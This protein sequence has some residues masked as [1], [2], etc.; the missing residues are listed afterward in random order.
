MLAGFDIST[1][2][3]SQP[4]YLWL[5]VVPAVLLVLGGWRV[6]R[7]SLDARRSGAGRISP[8]VQRHAR[9]GDLGFWFFTVLATSL[10]ILALARPQATTSVVRRASADFIMLQDGSASMYARDVAPDRWRRSI[11]F[12]RTFAESL[13]WRGDR[14]A[15]ALFAHRASAQVR[16]TSDPNALFFFLDHLGDRSPFRLEDPPTWDTNIEEGL[17]WGL[18][19]VTYHEEIF[20]KSASAKA[21]VVISD[22]Q[23]WS[24]QVSAALEVAR[25]RGYIVHV[26]GV[27]TTAGALIPNPPSIFEEEE[28]TPIRAVLDRNSL[29]EIARAGGGNYFELDQQPDRQ[30][31]SRI[32][33]NVQR[34]ATVVQAEETR[35]DLYAQCLLAAAVLLWLGVLLLRNSTQLWSLAAVAAAALFVIATAYR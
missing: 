28:S 3:F 16:L 4:L 5:L 24:G 12:L 2:T 10:C 7:R 22:G 34:R 13:A 6:L 30:L 27:G 25:A 9:L 31:A 17:Y 23:A 33:A 35:T 11:Q 1:L 18:N 20:G 14:V 21:F 15:L 32:I 8:V 26:I 19:L 29:N